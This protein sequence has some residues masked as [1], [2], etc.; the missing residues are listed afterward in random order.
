ME[1]AVIL[2]QERL[3]RNRQSSLIDCLQFSDKAQV[4][5]KKPEILQLFGFTSKNAAV[6][7]I[8]QLESFRNNLAHAQDIVTHDWAAI[9][10]IA[11]RLEEAVML[12]RSHPGD[13]M[14]GDT[15]R[16]GKRR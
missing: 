2:Q 12:R 6:E 8:K 15:L 5:M 7:A 11:S 4:L 14:T 13:G 1:K 3:R 9:A 16:R 10:R